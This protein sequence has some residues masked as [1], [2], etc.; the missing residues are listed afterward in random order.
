MLNTDPVTAM[1]VSAA[2]ALVLAGFGV[3][4][5]T[6]WGP[7]IPAGYRRGD[8]DRET[9]RTMSRTMFFTAGCTAVSGC[10]VPWDGTL[11][12]VVGTA[13]CASLIPAATGY[14]IYRIAMRRRD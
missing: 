13:V 5:R 1:A 3:L 11:P 4:L 6:R 9:R 8:N 7:G 2:V 10:L 14:A 12:A